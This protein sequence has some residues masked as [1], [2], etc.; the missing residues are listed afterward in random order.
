MRKCWKKSLRY[1]YI[2]PCRRV[3]SQ[4]AREERD[5]AERAVVPELAAL[6]AE[7]DV[8]RDAVAPALAARDV[9]A[10]QV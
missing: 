2:T 7:G 8:L 4:Q 6:L 10:E 5:L 3:F 1:S 9:Q